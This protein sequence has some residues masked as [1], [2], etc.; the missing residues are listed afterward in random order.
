VRERR[1]GREVEEEVQTGRQARA[2]EV[3]VGEEDEEGGEAGKKYLARWR[4]HGRRRPDEELRASRGGARRPALLLASRRSGAV[5]ETPGLRYSRA[6]RVRA[7]SEL[8]R[9][10]APA[11]A[12][13]GRRT[14]A[15][16]SS[17]RVWRAARARPAPQRRGKVLLLR[18]H[19]HGPAEKH[20]RRAVTLSLGKKQRKH[21]ARCARRL[22][23][24]QART[25]S[26]RN[27]LGRPMR[28]I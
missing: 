17:L 8:R 1:Q 19:A 16:S 6:A 5:R 13:T 10:A 24:L 26:S 12:G 20:G 21:E 23:A 28:A 15:S 2:G 9:A 14:L 11:P 3:V 4:R 25:A 22:H 27:K 18:V 7:A